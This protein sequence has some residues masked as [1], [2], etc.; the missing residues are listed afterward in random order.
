MGNTS[1]NPEK[2]CTALFEERKR[3]EVTIDK[4][5][6]RSFDYNRNNLKPGIDGNYSKIAKGNSRGSM[7]SFQQAEATANV[8]NVGT[9]TSPLEPTLLTDEARYVPNGNVTAGNTEYDAF[10]KTQNQQ[11]YIESLE[12]QPRLNRDM[13]DEEVFR[14][15]QSNIRLILKL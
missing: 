9:K 5:D 8:M 2:C 15:L 12:E 6:R 4:D 13:T 11:Q 10:N 14:F 1:C 3:S 7:S